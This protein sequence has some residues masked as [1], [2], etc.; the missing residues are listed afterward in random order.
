MYTF[1]SRVRYSEVDRSLSLDTASIINYF[2]DCSTFQSEDLGVGVEWL[3]EHHRVWLM[4]AWQIQI[5]SAPKLGDN[6]RIGT[7][8]YDF[9]S[10]YGYRNFLIQNADGTPAAAA[11]SIWVNVDTETGRPVK[12]T[13]EEADIYP[14]EPPYPMEYAPRKIALPEDLIVQE[15]FSVPRSS[16]DSNNHVNNGQYIRMAEN[17]L[18]EGFSVRQLRAEYRK[19][20]VLGDIIYPGIHRDEHTVTISLADAS[21]KPYCITEFSDIIPQATAER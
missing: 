16:L 6:I 18:P 11:N 21:G 8:A 17:Y 2:Q 20:A 12:I 9:K 19:A 10:M 14:H 1:N 3:K 15:P 13:P 4:N 5:Y 7:W